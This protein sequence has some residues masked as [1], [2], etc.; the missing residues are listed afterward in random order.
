MDTYKS[1]LENQDLTQSSYSIC[2]CR[3]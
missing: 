1:F 3:Q 2:Y